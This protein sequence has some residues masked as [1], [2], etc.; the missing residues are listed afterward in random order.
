MSYK[1]KY[2]NEAIAELNNGFI[3]YRSKEVELG[4]QFKDAFNKIRLEL[5]ENPKI[6][7]EVEGSHRRAVLGSSFP[8]TVHYLIDEKNKTIKVIGVFHQSREVEL[9][10]EKIKIRKIRQLK[11]EKNLQFERR[12]SQLNKTRKSKEL[13]QEI[14]RKRGRGLEL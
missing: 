4:Q 10:N 6:F 9:V 11:K 3:W 8:Y 7:K 14:E 1:I 13:E 2:T 5:K 12:L